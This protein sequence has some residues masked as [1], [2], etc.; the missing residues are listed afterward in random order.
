MMKESERKV[1]FSKM[2]FVSICTVTMKPI[3]MNA[4]CL[5]VDSNITNGKI[6]QNCELY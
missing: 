3:A 4:D 6:V 2:M 1:I 5:T